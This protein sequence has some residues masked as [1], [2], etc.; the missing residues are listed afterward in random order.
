MKKITLALFLMTLIRAAHA[1]DLYTSGDFWAPCNSSGKDC[2]FN[3]Q[4]NLD[5]TDDRI[6]GKVITMYGVAACR[7]EDVPI[8]G[9]VTTQGE[10]RW[11]SDKNPVPGCGSLVFQGRKEGEALIGYFPKF[12]GKQVDLTLVKK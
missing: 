6:S 9:S 8:N 3:L 1:A 10:V 7:W 5:I 2:R 4:L 11:R 12:Q